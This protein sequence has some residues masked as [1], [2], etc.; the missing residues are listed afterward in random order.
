MSDIQAQLEEKK[1]RLQAIK[2][3]KSKANCVGEHS[4][5]KDVE[6]KMKIEELEDDIQDLDAYRQDLASVIH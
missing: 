5:G 4:S 2:T 3:S 6:R 1:A